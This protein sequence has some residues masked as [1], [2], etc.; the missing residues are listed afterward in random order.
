M[1]GV[2]DFLFEGRPPT[3]VTTYGQTVDNIPKWMSDYTQGLIGRANVIA[4][5]PYQAY[6]GPRIA[7]FQP[8]QMQGFQAIRDN[9]GSYAPGY[10]GAAQEFS[11]VSGMNPLAAAQ[12]YLNQGTQEFSGDAVNQYMDPYIQNVLNRQEEL[13]NRNFRENL[14]PELQNTFVGSGAFGGDRMADIAG[15]IT[16]DTAEGLQGQQLGAL[17]EGYRQAGNL[18][19]ADQGRQLQAGQVAGGLEQAGG[20]LGLQTGR[21]MQQLGSDVSRM[22]VADAQALEAIGSQQQQLGQGSLDL[23]YQD[24]L[25]QRDYPREMVDWMSGVVRGLPSDR[26]QDRTEVGPSSSYGPSPLSQVGSLYSI[27]RGTQPPQGG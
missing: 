6:E 2:L 12:P 7:G 13:S 16:R 14:M 18:F 4:A 21:A 19:G 23:A 17:S 10:S 25:R 1:P 27:Y 26:V 15:R 8:D 9:I 11:N 20:Q 24:F 5:E 3:S 22:G